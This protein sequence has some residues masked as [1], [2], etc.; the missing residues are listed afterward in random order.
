MCNELEALPLSR[1]VVI[2]LL[3]LENVRRNRIRLHVRQ[4]TRYSAPSFGRQGRWYDPLDQ[5]RSYHAEDDTIWG[6]GRKPRASNPKDAPDQPYLFARKVMP[7]DETATNYPAKLNE[8][9]L[10]LHPNL[11][12]RHVISATDVLRINKEFRLQR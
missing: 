5:T 3:N 9:A 6:V 8:R 7:N 12:Q 1:Y 4:P 2:N 11:M 10:N